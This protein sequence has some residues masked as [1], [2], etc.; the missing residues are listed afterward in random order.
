MRA[1]QPVRGLVRILLFSLDSADIFKA[2]FTAVPVIVRGCFVLSANSA[3]EKE[4]EW[5]MA[6]ELVSFLVEWDERN[7][8]L[9]RKQ[10]LGQEECEQMIAALITHTS[11]QAVW[12]DIFGSEK[13][14]SGQRF[15]AVVS[16]P[17][18]KQ[19]FFICFTIRDKGAGKAV[20]IIEIRT[21]NKRE[22][23]CWADSER[24]VPAPPLR[25]LLGV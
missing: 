8:G 16:R 4:R 15:V 7:L 13:E 5:D 22:P 17:Y 25:Q 12:I 11:S 10:G 21:A 2:R 1:R 6:G 24:F 9:V 14:R 3:K 20:R 18:P 19:R 23:L